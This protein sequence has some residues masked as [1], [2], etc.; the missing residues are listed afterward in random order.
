MKYAV[1]KTTLFD[2]TT[3]PIE[4]SL[5]IWVSWRRDS[6]KAKGSTMTVDTSRNDDE[7]LERLP[8]GSVVVLQKR[9]GYRFSIDAVLLAGFVRLKRAD[10][11]AELGSG[12]GIVSLL[13]A[14]R[15]Q[16]ALITGFE[17]QDEMTDMANRSAAL[18]GLEKRTTFIAVDV[19]TVRKH[20]GAESFDVVFFNPPYRKSGSGRVNPQERKAAAR[21][22]LHG[23][24]DDFLESAAFLLK[25]KG[26]LY[27]IYPAERS[28]TLLSGLRTRRIE[29]KKLRFVH[30]FAQS[31]A[32]FVLVE[33]IKG[34]GEE[35]R[36]EPPLII[37]ESPGV[38][39][40]EVSSIFN[41]KNV[42][43]ANGE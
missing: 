36:V 37:Y 1:E 26:R 38:Y 6:R 41:G 24:I 18:N 3:F 5:E 43:N 30:S 25:A 16:S 11:A 20:C 27:A 32:S 23:T 39:A 31:A 40:A 19:R 21:H 2:V 15:Y 7:T 33:A 12:S 17:I 13:L 10:R 35:L 34:A 42:R 29:P 9:D 4:N 22:E 14:A 28:V 8:G